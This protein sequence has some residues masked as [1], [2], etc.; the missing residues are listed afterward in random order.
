MFPIASLK[1]T[2]TCVA[3]LNQ[4]SLFSGTFQGGIPHEGTCDVLPGRWSL[5]HCLSCCRRWSENAGW[6]A[7]AG[8]TEPRR[9]CKASAWSRAGQGSQHAGGLP[10]DCSPS[11]W[12]A[13]PG[14][15]CREDP[16]FP[17]P[18]AVRGVSAESSGKQ[19][20]GSGSGRCRLPRRPGWR[21]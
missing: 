8:R 10:P 3:Q 5:R 2:R 11:G 18:A 16:W 6:T 19:P 1:I 9:P 13:V 20:E 15:T 21:A 12:V 17:A 7:R 4:H 14:Q